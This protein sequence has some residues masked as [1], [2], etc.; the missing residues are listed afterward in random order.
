[1]V[2]PIDRWFWIWALGNYLLGDTVHGAWGTGMESYGNS[3]DARVFGTDLGEEWGNKQQGASDVPVI[4]VVPEGEELNYLIES[5]RLGDFL[6]PDG[7][8]GLRDNPNE[9]SPSNRSSNS[10]LLPDMMG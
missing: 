7:T 10:Q 8:T 5:G 1:L 6:V 9:F 3:S 4:I 2:F